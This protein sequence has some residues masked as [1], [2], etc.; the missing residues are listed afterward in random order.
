M[1]KFNVNDIHACMQRLCRQAKVKAIVGHDQPVRGIS[2]TG[3][4]FGVGR[5]KHAVVDLNA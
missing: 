4:L 2:V 5:S 3:I 1:R